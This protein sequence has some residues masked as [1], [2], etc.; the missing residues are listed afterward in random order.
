MSTD[1]AANLAKGIPVP[2]GGMVYE[3]LCQARAEFL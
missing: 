2:L 3:D 1:W